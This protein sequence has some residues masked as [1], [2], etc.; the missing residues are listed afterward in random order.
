MALL[1]N[2]YLLDTEAAE[3]R[4]NDQLIDVEPQVFDLISFLATNAGRIVS[5]DEL[6]DAVWHGRV[7]SDSTISTRIGA[8]RRALGDDGAS[9]R[10]IKTIHSRGF[11]FDVRPEL[12]PSP[13]EPSAG[14][15]YAQRPPS[16]AD[17]R[18]V[19]YFRSH[20]GTSIAHT[21]VGSGYPVVFGG[22]W[23]SHLE[24]DWKNPGWGPYVKHLAAHFQVIRYDLRGNGM[25]AWDDV[26]ISF[27]RMVEDM[28]C[29]IDVYGL[30][31]VAI[32][33]G[34]QGAAI[35]IAY[36]AQFPQKVSHLVLYGGYP[37]GRRRRGDPEAEAE[38]KALVTL[39][40]QGWARKNPAIRQQIT[41]MLMP[42]ATQDEAKWF[43]E[44]Q[45]DC[46]PAENI[47]QFRKVFD[48]IDV[49]ALLERVE[50]PTLILRNV[51][52]AVAPLSEAKL[53]ASRI[54]RSRLM[55]LNS[56]NH[57]IL[58]NDPEFPRFLSSMVEF[59]KTDPAEL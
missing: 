26:D 55:T 45:R 15:A 27:D 33:G 59:L 30:D 49:S 18:S 5:K 50:A 38:S 47:A 22:A 37:R 39:I 40:R 32:F 2:D 31:R 10:I 46:A 11:R 20:D 57:M 52:D 42:D 24:Q 54:R 3:L 16:V 58:E 29:T 9:Q 43:N 12:W 23:I 44:F 4:Y 34:S 7:I 14:P 1:I 19:R 36:A 48:E 8:A 13:N 25:S 28:E 41:A 53:M 51:G 35:A 21:E 17:Q 6:I 56:E